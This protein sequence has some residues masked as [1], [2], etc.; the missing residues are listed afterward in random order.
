M[1]VDLLT[2]AAGASMVAAGAL[3]H[4]LQARIRGE[5]RFDRTSRAL[6]A[7]DSSNYRHVPIGVVVP[8]DVADV[9]TAIEVARCHAA[10]ILA[11]GGGTSLAG[12]TCNTAVV[13]D[14]SKYVNR[15][16]EI[17]A[18]SHRARV[19]PGLVL[20]RLRDAAAPHGLTF[21]PD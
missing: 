4:D 8:R 1:N 9:V 19:E 16:L 17:N 20:D 11:R 2:R 14:A 12:Q 7:T 10:P 21:G 5:V 3:A 18:R 6:Y 13:I 15:V